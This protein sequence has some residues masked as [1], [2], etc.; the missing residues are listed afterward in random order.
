MKFGPDLKTFDFFLRYHSVEYK[1]EVFS[2]SISQ[3][4][5]HR[6]RGQTG[7]LLVIQLHGAPRIYKRDE[8]MW[9]REVDF[10]P[11]SSIGYL[12]GPSLGENFFRLVDPTNI[13]IAYIE[14]AL[15]H[16]RECCYDPVSWLTEQYE[17]YSLSGKIPDTPE[18][19]LDDGLVYV[20]KIQ[21][22]PSK[23]PPMDY[24]PQ[25]TKVSDKDVTI[26]G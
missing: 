8:G 23:F 13:N 2:E 7:K 26:E 11:S 3:I 1:L 21:I 16:L 17:Q 18:I 4:E 20:P 15:S 5:L 14:H 12:P 19:A 24:T 25:P 10:T 22:T 6:P 9:V